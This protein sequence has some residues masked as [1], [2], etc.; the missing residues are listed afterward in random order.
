MKKQFVKPEIEIIAFSNEDD[1]V[2]AS[3]QT[4]GP[5]GGEGVVDGGTF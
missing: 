3:T 1:I 4:I 5:I 2:T